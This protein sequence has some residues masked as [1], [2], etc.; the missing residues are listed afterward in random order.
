M[1]SGGSGEGT[2]SR[3]RDSVSFTKAAAADRCVLCVR[4]ETNSPDVAAA[5]GRK[6]DKR[7]LA[8]G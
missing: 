2:F 7:K 5:E 3:C 4:Q 6:R 8:G 1:V